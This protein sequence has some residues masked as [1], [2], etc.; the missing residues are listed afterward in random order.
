[1]SLNK[2]CCVQSRTF[3]SRVSNSHVFNNS[4]VFTSH[5]ALV[6]LFSSRVSRVQRTL[7]CLTLPL[8]C[9]TLTYLYAILNSCILNINSR[10]FN[11]CVIDINPRVL[12]IISHVFNFQQVSKKRACQ[13]LYPM[14]DMHY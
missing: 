13:L 11:S 4:H 8:V 12:N 1:M 2:Q 3:N 9:S 5:V 14:K 10:V 6:F 7:A